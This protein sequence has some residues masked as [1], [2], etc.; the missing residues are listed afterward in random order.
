MPAVTIHGPPIATA[1][2]ATEERRA[3]QAE[4]LWAV[5]GGCRRLSAVVGG[6]RRLSARCHPDVHH[7]THWGPSTRRSSRG[8]SD[9][10]NLPIKSKRKP[11]LQ[12][13][14]QIKQ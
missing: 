9:K 3:A 1:T 8:N 4:R 7:R 6:C 13:I 12:I 11:A 14:N 5:V 2:P 10:S